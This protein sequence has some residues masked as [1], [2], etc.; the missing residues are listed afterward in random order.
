MV[1]VPVAQMQNT[2]AVADGT[3]QDVALVL[4]RF[5]FLIFPV[6]L[7]SFPSSKCRR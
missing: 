3:E 7:P 6:P 1:V 5:S 2:A 4:A